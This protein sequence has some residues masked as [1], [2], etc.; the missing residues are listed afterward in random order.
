MKI[1][2]V[3]I[4]L[5]DSDSLINKVY[6]RLST[7]RHK[8]PMGKANIQVFSDG[9]TCVDFSTP[10]RGKR[11][12]LVTSPNTAQKREQLYFAIDAAR[13][14]SAVEIIPI[15][16]YFPYARQD[17]RDQRRGPIGAR[18]YADMLQ[19][20]GATSIITF[21]LHSDQIEGFFKIPV[22]HLR[23]KYLFCDYI[24]IMIDDMCDTG[25]TL[26]KGAEA[27]VEHGA[28]SVKVLVTHAILSGDASVNLGASIIEQFIC[29]DSL[30]H[31][32][33]CSDM[34]EKMK[35]ISTASDLANA[36]IS[37]N[38]DGSINR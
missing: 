20:V 11:V 2:S 38:V 29:S 24:F 35:V 28:T 7:M 33:L 27:L 4:N 13:R 22:I 15:L 9:E 16:A 19:D 34:D 17:K 3:I 8:V 5:N 14:A 32:G 25:G 6:E 18:V 21:D 12:L 1:D 10:V 31:K 30:T 26:I 23:G 37:I 36:I